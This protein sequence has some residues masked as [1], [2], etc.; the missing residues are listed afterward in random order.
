[1][2]NVSEVICFCYLLQLRSGIRDSDEMAASFIR[3]YSLLYALKEVLFENI[4]FQRTSR[5]AGYDEQRIRKIH[6]L[7]ECLDL[8]GIGGI[9]NV[10]FGIARNRA[11]S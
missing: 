2:E 10:Q 7:L 11:E 1:M 4:W 5:F 8:R 6:F 9:K 3:A